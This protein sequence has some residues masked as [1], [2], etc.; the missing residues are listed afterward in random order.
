MI[1][2]DNFM[3]NV[4]KDTNLGYIRVIAKGEGGIA[5]ERTMDGLAASEIAAFMNKELESYYKI[6]EYWHVVIS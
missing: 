2:G 1:K 4:A 3:V 6:G 5:T